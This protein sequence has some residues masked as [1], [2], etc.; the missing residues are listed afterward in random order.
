MP[1]E[2]LNQ[3]EQTGLTATKTPLSHKVFVILCLLGFFTGTLTAIMTYMNLGYTEHFLMDWFS[4]F[5]SSLLVIPIGFLVM[6]VI[7]KLIN[8]KYP[9]LSELQR[10]LITGTIMAVIMEAVMS[11]S[12][13]I[14]NIG[15]ADL[16]NFYQGWLAGYL[17]SLP[18]GLAIMVIMSLT[19]KPKI[20]AFIRS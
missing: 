13:A 5:L 8:Q 11:C 18:V 10:N 20:E 19:I 16:G 1:L 4:S 7:T 14:N 2:L 9:L 3:N 12:T 17:G 6:A 15:L